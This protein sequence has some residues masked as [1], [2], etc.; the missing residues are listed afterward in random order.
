MHRTRIAIV[1]ASIALTLAC[2]EEEAPT[3]SPDPSGVGGSTTT[4]T[5]SGGAGGS[6]N[7]NG[8]GGNATSGAGGGTDVGFESGSRLRA[9]TMHGADG[10]WQFSGWH[11]NQLNID[12]A[13]TLAVDG[14]QRCLPLTTPA[15]VANYSRDSNCQLHATR[16]PQL[17]AK[18]TFALR[19]APVY[20]C[21]TGGRRVYTVNNVLSTLYKKSGSCF[22]VTNTEM[23][24]WNSYA[25]TEAAP[26]QFAEGTEQVE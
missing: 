9:R 8:G 11:D 5:A 7:S 13:Y 18:P 21:S 10:S 24:G 25:V 19:P 12:C 16:L 14:K 1:A 3:V 15:T 17:C 2:A 4:T 20:A 22:N 6:T 26:T 23:A